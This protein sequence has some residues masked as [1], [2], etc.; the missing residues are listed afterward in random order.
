MKR[1]RQVAEAYLFLIAN[2]VKSMAG[3]DKRDFISGL[4]DILQKQR[5]VRRSKDDSLHPN[6]LRVKDI[7]DIPQDSD[8]PKESARAII[9]ML[10]PY[11]NADTQNRVLKYV[12]KGLKENYLN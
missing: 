1:T 6:D 3:E 9:T 10:H 8:N 12:I 5:F 4:V 2:S 7:E 11:Y